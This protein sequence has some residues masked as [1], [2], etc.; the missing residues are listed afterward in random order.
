MSR[1]EEEYLTMK[2][3]RML[4]MKRKDVEDVSEDFS[5]FSLSSPARKIRRLDVEL[6]PIMEEDREAEN[7]SINNDNSSSMT[8]EEE[9]E[10]DDEE[11]L[12]R[13][14]VVFRPVNTYFV[15]Q[16]SPSNFSVTLDSDVISNFKDQF[17][18]SGSSSE[19][20][21]EE[22]EEGDERKK[23]LAVVPWRNPAPILVNARPETDA[24]EEAM[25]AEEMEIEDKNCSSIEQSREFNPIPHWQQQHCM[26][27]QLPPNTSSTPVTWF[28]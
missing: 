8:I 14:I 24:P 17:L 12:E 10:N 21:L 5:D 13:A 25:E 11:N 4:K 16:S 2:M 27:P 19:V 18:R 6:P 23:S 22:E 9:E 20:R 3:K 7:R 15:H 28:Q 26:M 1:G